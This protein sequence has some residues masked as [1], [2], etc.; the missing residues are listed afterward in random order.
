MKKLIEKDKKFRSNIFKTE[1]L[2]FVLKSI[3]KNINYFPLIRWNAF[4]KLEKLLPKSNK[5]ILS[6]RCLMTINKKR[7]N[8]LT[9]FS[10]HIFLK[11][12]R[13]GQINGMKKSSW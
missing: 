11:L 7:F 10:R 3:F 12:I 1:T 4:S 6:N 5:I 13:S 2:H 8:K 9:L